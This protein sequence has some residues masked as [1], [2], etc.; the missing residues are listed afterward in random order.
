MITRVRGVS[1]CYV[2]ECFEE[3]DSLD[4]GPAHAATSCFGGV[5]TER[6][7]GDTGRLLLAKVALKCSIEVELGNDHLTWIRLA[8]ANK[9]ATCVEITSLVWKVDLLI[10]AKEE[11]NEVRTIR[12]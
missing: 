6:D 4:K 1:S 11:A 3:L 8:Q 7:P 2:F 10:L 5:Y 12:N 9:T